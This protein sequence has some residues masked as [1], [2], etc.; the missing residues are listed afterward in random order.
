MCNHFSVLVRTFGVKTLQQNDNASHIFEIELNSVVID[1]LIPTY[2]ISCPLAFSTTYCLTDLSET[3]TTKQNTKHY[4][5]ER[6]M[7]CYEC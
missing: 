4:E 5:S 3:I 2:L 7:A 1:Y 6:N